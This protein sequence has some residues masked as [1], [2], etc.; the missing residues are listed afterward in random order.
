MPKLFLGL[1]R[2]SDWGKDMFWEL[3][4]TYMQ[5]INGTY[6]TRNNVMRSDSAF[7]EYESVNQTEVLQEY[8]VPVEQFLAYIDE[9]RSVLKQHEL[10]VLNITVRYVKKN[11]HAV[12]S[13]AKEDM[14]AL[15]LL[16]NQGRS[17]KEVQKT[18][19]MIRDMIDVT[20]RHDGSYYLP[21]YPYPTKAQLYQA[22]PRIEEF[23]VKKRKYDPEERF[24]NLFYKEYGQ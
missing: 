3:Q 7:M 24:V 22:Y 10:N 9:L 17:E 14:F 5:Q 19:D 11:D 1:S 2:Y 6:E 15:V 4:R 13:Y 21:Y 16:I 12:L 23:F 20:L 8:F 18:G